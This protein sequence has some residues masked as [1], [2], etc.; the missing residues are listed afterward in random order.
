MDM[1]NEPQ[2]MLIIESLIED[3]VATCN[4]EEMFHLFL[5]LLRGHFSRMSNEQL[6]HLMQVRSLDVDSLA[7]N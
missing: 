6:F 3:E 5:K 2:R 7:G 4:T 1:M